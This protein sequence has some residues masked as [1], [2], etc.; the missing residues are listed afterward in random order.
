VAGVGGAFVCL[1]APR[2]VVQLGAALA[3]V[4]RV[5]PAGDLLI[6]IAVPAGIM[7]I[8]SIAVLAAV[9]GAALGGDLSPP[10]L[11][12]RWAVF[13]ALGTIGAL[14]EEIGWRGFL[15][16]RLPPARPGIVAVGMAAVW[17]AWHLPLMLW[18]GSDQAPLTALGIALFGAEL[19]GLTA[20]L[21]FLRTHSGSTWTA[22]LAHGSHNAS[23][24]VATLLVTSPADRATYIGPQAGLVPTALYLAVGLL[25]VRASTGDRP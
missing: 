18:L 13:V 25:A 22:A 23:W 17:L 19:L 11:A 10:A 15:I 21:N 14:G 8:G 9:P 7:T 2:H 20:F 5:T 1:R 4:G 12:A 3:L 24:A 16:P 6:A